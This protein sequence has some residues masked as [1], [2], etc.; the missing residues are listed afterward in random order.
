MPATRDH[1]KSSLEYDILYVT[2]ESRSC[3]SE[4][5]R[6]SPSRKGRILADFHPAEAGDRKMAAGPVLALVF[7]ILEPPPSFAHLDERV[8]FRADPRRCPARFV[9]SAT[10]GVAASTFGRLERTWA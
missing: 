9:A 2:L 7:Y 4:K 1:L 10:S 6:E 8:R 5:R 3:T